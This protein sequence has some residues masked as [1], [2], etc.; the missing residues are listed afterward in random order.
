M[1]A[2]ETVETYPVAA[3][4]YPEGHAKGYLTHACR[5]DDDGNLRPLCRS[6]KAASILDDGLWDGEGCVGR[7][8]TCGPCCKRDPRDHGM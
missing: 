5:R 8:P 1:I 2:A 7:C 6:V 3:S 4:A